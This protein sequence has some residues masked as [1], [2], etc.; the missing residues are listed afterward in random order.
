MNRVRSDGS[1][2]PSTASS[3]PGA[4]AVGTLVPSDQPTAKVNGVWSFASARPC[5]IMWLAFVGSAFSPTVAAAGVLSPFVGSGIP[6]TQTG[7]FNLIG[8]VAAGVETGDAFNLADHARLEHK[9]ACLALI[10][11]CF[12]SIKK[13]R[14][15][16]VSLGL[17]VI[18]ALSSQH[19]RNSGIALFQG[20]DFVHPIG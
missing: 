14:T 6:L 20:R 3:A 17:L 16:R 8:R 1:T 5:N 2:G 4:A 12:V 18:W 7:I 15:R 19:R 9:T 11:T 13:T 10:Q